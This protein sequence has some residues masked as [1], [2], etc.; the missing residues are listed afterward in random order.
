MQDLGVW[1]LGRAV[2]LAF[3]FSLWPHVASLVRYGTGRQLS[4]IYFPESLLIY[5]LSG[6]R[7]RANLRD[8]DPAALKFRT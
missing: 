6:D 2:F 7:F 5:F 8:P 4:G 1:C 3:S